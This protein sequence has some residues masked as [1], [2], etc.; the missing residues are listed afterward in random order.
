MKNVTVI[1]VAHLS[2]GMQKEKASDLQLHSLL[3]NRNQRIA[4]SITLMSTHRR[5]GVPMVTAPCPHIRYTWAESN[6][7]E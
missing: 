4:E 1:P 2:K 7:N 3:V 6:D 5:L